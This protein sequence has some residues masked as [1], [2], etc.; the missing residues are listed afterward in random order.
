LYVPA[1]KSHSAD[2]YVFWSNSILAFQLKSGSSEIGLQIIIEECTKTIV[3]QL[4]NYN[5]TL[6]I[7]AA[8]LES[9]V[10]S[11]SGNGINVTKFSIQI[12]P[13][14]KLKWVSKKRVRTKNGPSES[15]EQKEIEYVIPPN[16]QLII[17]LE[18]G[19]ELFL[20]SYNMS[21]IQG[22]N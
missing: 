15:L 8:S 4:G 14:V 10:K 2:L 7:V 12:E 13:G 3:P 1:S 6:V 5:I 18:K 21:V 22:G 20:S 17:L 11:L 9:H 19:L 16:A